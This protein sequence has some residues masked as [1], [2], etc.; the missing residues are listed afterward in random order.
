MVQVNGAE[1]IRVKKL[2]PARI[3]RGAGPYVS[4]VGRKKPRLY[5]GGTLRDYIRKNNLWYVNIYTTMD[6]RVGKFELLEAPTDDNTFAIVQ[7]KNGTLTVGCLG[8]TM[9]IVRLGLRKPKRVV[10]EG[11]DVIV[12]W[13]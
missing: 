12:W 4:I 2:C 13:W 10:H 5:I 7:H 3:E 8:Y 6:Y 11:D 1:F 9:K